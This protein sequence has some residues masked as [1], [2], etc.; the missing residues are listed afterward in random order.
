MEQGVFRVPLNERLGR[1]CSTTSGTKVADN[2]STA[3][4]KF[5]VWF[6]CLNVLDNNNE[7]PPHSG[8]EWKNR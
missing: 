5:S 4:G 1:L 2:D 7:Q 8:M 6:I 3:K